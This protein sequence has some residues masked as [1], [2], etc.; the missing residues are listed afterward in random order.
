MNSCQHK[1]DII[2]YRMGLLTGDKKRAFEDHL[3]TCLICR[4]DMKVEAALENNLATPVDPGN[5]ESFIISKVRLIKNIQPQSS[6]QFLFQVGVYV[7]SAITLLRIFVP[8]IFS[9]FSAGE[10]GITKFIE[11]FPAMPASAMPATVIG[12][13]VLL[14]LTSGIL[15]YRT[16]R[17]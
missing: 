12:I 4:E 11:S 17:Q 9:L 13:G 16:L 5:I 8:M 6:W 1:K 14:A 7:V 15:A 10:A 2:A 3:R